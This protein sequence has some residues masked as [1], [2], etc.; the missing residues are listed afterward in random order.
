MSRT[1]YTLA[2]MREP[3]QAGQ[4]RQAD[5]LI[6]VLYSKEHKENFHQLRPPHETPFKVVELS[7]NK[8]KTSFA[9]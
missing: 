9:K 8:K 2:E 7:L 1:G 3:E 5:C 4:V 6:A